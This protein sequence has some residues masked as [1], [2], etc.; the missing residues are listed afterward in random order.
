MKEP[1]TSRELD[2][3]LLLQ[4]FHVAVSEGDWETAL[5]RENQM[6]VMWMADILS[7]GRLTPAL[8]TLGYRINAL[9]KEDVIK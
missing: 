5:D 4:E 7:G 6:Q 1:I 3:D 9:G 2:Y 8:Q